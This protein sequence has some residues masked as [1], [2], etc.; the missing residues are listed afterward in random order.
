MQI[1]DLKIGIPREIMDGEKRVAASPDSVVKMKE[2]G[3]QVYLEQNAGQGAFISDED[4]LA[5]GAEIVKGPKELYGNVDVVLKVK[6]PCFNHEYGCHEVEFMQENSL[7]ICFLHPANPVNHDMVRMLAQKKITSL[8]LDGIP[9]I[10]RA[11]Q[12]D[13]LTSMS[14][15]AGYKSAILAANLLARFVPMMPTASGV[16]QPAQFLVVGT[17]VVGLQAIGMVKRMGGKVKSLDIRKEANEQSKSLGAELVPFDVPDELAAGEGGYAKR[18]PPEWYQ[19]ERDILAELVQTCDAIILS[20]LIP[21]EESPILLEKSMIEKMK[22]GSVIIDIAVDQ[23]GNC[24]VTRPGENYV[25]EGIT[26]SGIMNLPATL[27]ID[28]TKMI[29]FNM[30]HLLTYLAKHGLVMNTEDEIIKS[31]LVTHQGEVVHRG[32]L[33]AMERQKSKA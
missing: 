30:W 15:I 32:T 3:A 10:S 33:L 18:L 8:T 27:A 7:L 29:S 2:A 22:K 28:A 31:S 20:A 5:S 14:S 25:Y 9:R 6:E 19:K 13:A 11:Q 23:G 1:S 4:Y 21:G 26:V 16:I 17:G 24:E 12:M